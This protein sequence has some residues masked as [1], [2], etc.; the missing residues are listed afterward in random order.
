MRV[1][2]RVAKLVITICRLI[3]WIIQLVKEIVECHGDYPL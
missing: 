3:F 2:E 1:T